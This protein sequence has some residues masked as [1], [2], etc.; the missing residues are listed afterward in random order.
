MYYLIWKVSL[1]T[2]AQK[3]ALFN[4][5]N[6]LSAYNPPA[7]VTAW[8]NRWGFSYPNNLGTQQYAEYIE[9]T[10]PVSSY[11]GSIAFPVFDIIYPGFLELIPTLK[12]MGLPEPDEGISLPLTSLPYDWYEPAPPLPIAT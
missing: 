2:K 8:L 1:L 11:F 12:T 4:K 3:K 6:K 5:L 10:N 9:C 7:A